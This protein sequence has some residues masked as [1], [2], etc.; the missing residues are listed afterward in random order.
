[1]SVVFALTNLYDK[2]VTSF[3]ADGIDCAFSFGWRQPETHKT[4]RRQIIFIPGDESGSLGDLVAPRSPGNN[5]R[6]L[7]NLDELFTVRVEAVDIK[8]A[9]NER[10]QYQAT[11]ELFD[12]FIRAMYHAAHGTY[13]VQSLDWD[14]SKKVR[15]HGAAIIMIAS[16]KAIIPDVTHDVVPADA[17]G[18]ITT[19]LEDVDEKTLEPTP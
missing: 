17:E 10:A 12:L 9:E 14:T 2:V 11:R 19:S 8:D 18:D 7:H 6:A 4:T 1:M 13:D 5:P 16:I 3:E 15:R